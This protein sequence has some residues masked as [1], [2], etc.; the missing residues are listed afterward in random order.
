MARLVLWSVLVATAVADTALSPLA[1]SC[2]KGTGWSGSKCAPC[3]PGFYC[4]DGS[5]DTQGRTSESD[6]AK[7]CAAGYYCPSGSFTRKGRVKGVGIHPCPIGHYCPRL[8]ASGTMHPCAPGYFRNTTGAKAESDCR[9]CDAG[10]ANGRSGQSECEPCPQ[11]KYSGPAAPGCSTCADGEYSL[12]QGNVRCSPCRVR[13]PFSHLLEHL[14]AY[15]RR[16]PIRVHPATPV[17][18]TFPML[19]FGTRRHTP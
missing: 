12:G 13:I 5:I 18:K 2:L 17:L 19:P 14:G 7:G 6:S 15:R 8:S 1:K 4:R 3:Q 16:A 10:T 11:Q 9:P